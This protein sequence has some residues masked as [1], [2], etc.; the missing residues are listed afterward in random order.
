MTPIAAPWAGAVPTGVAAGSAGTA[1]AGCRGAGRIR[2]GRLVLLDELLHGS[3]LGGVRFD[4]GPPQLPGDEEA[5]NHAE[6]DQQ[7]ADHL[8]SHQRAPRGGC[9]GFPARRRRG[10][11]VRSTCHSC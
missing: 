8:D 4:V 7:F 3:P 5:G 11:S 2:D 10:G 9:G 6:G 1:G